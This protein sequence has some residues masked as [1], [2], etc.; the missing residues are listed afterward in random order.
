MP[1]EWRQGA[2]ASGE[3]TPYIGAI[4]DLTPTLSAYASY[5]DI[6]IPQTARTVDGTVL[7]PRVGAQV[8][9][10]L[11]GSF[12]DG[13]LDASIAAFRSRERNRSMPDPSNPG[14]F[15]QSGE[16]EVRGVEVEVAG[17]PLD[18]LQLAASYTWLDSSHIRHQTLTGEVFSLFEPRHTIKAYARYTPSD[19]D[20]AK[21][22]FVGGFLYSSGMIGTGGTSRRQDDYV[23]LN[24]Q[25]DYRLNKNVTASLQVENLLDEK[26]YA[27]VGGLNTYNTYGAP[28]SVSFALR[29]RF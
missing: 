8:E 16:T 28:R 17:T 29:S 12:F 11:K 26:Y 7:D 5:S 25:L 20:W 18:N 3:L 1:S 27:R 2:R 21:W 15:I 6:F 13:N 4:Y 24:A 9:A 19:P 10:G 22:T 14:F 23:V